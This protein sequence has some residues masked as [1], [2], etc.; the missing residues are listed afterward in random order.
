MMYQGKC[1][2]CG[3]IVRGG[4]GTPM[5]RIDTPVRTCF[6][7]GHNYIDENMYEW[8]VLDPVY[9][10]WF[11]FAA[12][13]RG[14][15]LLLS[16]LMGTSCLAVDN[17]ATGIACLVFSAIWMAISFVYVKLAHKDARNASQ[18]RCNNPEY[19]E[20][21]NAIKYDKLARKFNNFYNNN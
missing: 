3:N 18:I 15:V 4:H 13:N 21:L 14:I 11:I 12:N 19:I 1:P 10:F 16:L 5:K 2:H 8:A 6:R 9:K 20:L 17:I 7:C